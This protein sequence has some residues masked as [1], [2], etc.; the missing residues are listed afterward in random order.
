M[1]YL[2]I[3]ADAI[4]GTAEI[5]TD[6]TGLIARLAVYSLEPGGQLAYEYEG[7]SGQKVTRIE[8]MAPAGEGC[9]TYVCLDPDDPAPQSVGVGGGDSVAL[10]PDAAEAAPA[11]DAEM[12][13]L[14]MKPHIEPA[15]G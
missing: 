2:T 9:V 15:D 10:E 6:H 4:D 5:R 1:L 12:R 13:R 8:M 7:E 11:S 3:P 14:A